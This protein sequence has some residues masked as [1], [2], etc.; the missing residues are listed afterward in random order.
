MNEPGKRN[1]IT[2]LSLG[3]LLGPLLFTLMT[4]ICSDLRPHYNHM[5]Q[6]ISELAATGTTYAALMNYAGFIPVGLLCAMF[7]ISLLP[8]VP[9]SIVGKIGAILIGLFGIGVVLAGALSCDEGCPPKDGSFHNRMHNGISGF[10]F[11][12]LIIGILLT[13]LAFRRTD[14][15][16][17]YW[18]YCLVTAF[19]S[20]VF[21]ILLSNSLDSPTGKGLWQRLFLLTVFVWLSITGV[22]VFNFRN[23]RLRSPK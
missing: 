3:G 7:G 2:Y 4:V 19:V 9:R 5:N 12:V 1:P 17:R 6:F 13:G 11:L 20:G 22:T 16:K 18:I 14:F 23:S 21:M 8:L 15:Q 10:A